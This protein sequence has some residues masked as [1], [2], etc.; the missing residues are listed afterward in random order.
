MKRFNRLTCNFSTASARKEFWN[1]KQWTVV[2]AVIMTEGVRAG[3]EG[4]KLYTRREMSKNVST[5]NMKP[6]VVDH[7]TDGFGEAV[8]ACSREIVENQGVGLMMNTEFDDRIKTEA[9]FEDSR[10]YGPSAIEPRIGQAI[11]RKQPLEVST[12]VF[13]EDDYSPGTYQG[14]EYSYIARNLRAD[15]LAVLLDREG[16]CSIR[17]G[18]GLLTNAR[19]ASQ[20]GIKVQQTDTF[21]GFAKQSNG[22]YLVMVNGKITGRICPGHPAYEVAQAAYEEQ[23]REE[24]SYQEDFVGD[25]LSEDENDPP[26]APIKKAPSPYDIEK[27]KMDAREAFTTGFQSDGHGSNPGAFQTNAALDSP[28]AESLPMQEMMLATYERQQRNPVANREY[29]A[30]PRRALT[31]LASGE[32]REA[33]PGD[34]EFMQVIRSGG[35]LTTNGPATNEKLPMPVMDCS[36]RRERQTANAA[37]GDSLPMPGYEF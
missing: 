2:P 16:A 5:W 23:Q 11:D 19:K 6:I 13:V 34:A 26:R 28:Y 29:G 22:D 21:T 18:C 30:D 20:M 36:R 35:M 8:S 17:E 7:P 27:R 10:I 9:W 37:S 12:G 3:S 14:K 31:M 1:G 25:R 33:L 4:P 32:L 15:H 24:G